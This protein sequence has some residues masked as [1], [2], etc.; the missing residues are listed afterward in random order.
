M[1]S[2]ST[3]DFAIVGSGFGGS[4]AALRLAEKGYRV[5]VL[6]Q[7]HRVDRARM[8]AA[9]SSLRWFMWAPGLRAFGYFAQ[10]VFQHVGILGGVG[11]GGGSLVYG[12]VL[13]QP[14]TA[15][16]DDPA[17][18]RLGVNWQRELEPHYRT[19]E[20]MLGRAITPDLGTMDEYLR[21][22]AIALGKADTFGPTP[23]GIYFGQQGL[24]APDPYFGGAGPSK[25]GCL[26][27]GRCLTGCPHGSKNSLDQNYLYLA[28]RK[29]V[30]VL[31]LHQVTRLTRTSEG[32]RLECRDVTNGIEHSPINARR[33]VLAAGVVGTLALLF[34]SRDEHGTLPDVSRHLGDGVRTNS[35]SIVGIY[36][37]NPPP[38][39]ADG[40]AISSH[41]HAS[42]HTH[43]TQNR[44]APRYAFM[45]F[46]ATPMIDD[47]Q[48]WRR[49]IRTLLAL[50]LPPWRVLRAMTRHD[51]HRR[52]TVLTVMQKVDNELR[53]RWGRSL[54][55]PF[56]RRL[57]SAVAVGA[58]PPTFLPEANAAARALA[59]QADGT[60][61]SFAPESVGNLSVTA[62]I[63]GGCKMGRTAEDG[64]IDTR[65]EVFGCPGLYVV[66]GSAVSANVGVNPSLTITALAE[67]A[68]EMIPAKG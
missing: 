14:K 4:V 34:R 66:D 61:F 60:P 39:L 30:A 2:E 41:F 45:R 52:V 11:V 6:E 38:D 56:R 18:S 5:V 57:L 23:N 64:V 26:R 43:L 35:E 55:W 51:W 68:M 15:F 28:E 3:Y 46:Y 50:L 13:L 63:L 33:V 8:E 59:R 21:R 17:W 67:R 20:R 36:H 9:E 40:T 22:T 24:E 37:D 12:A 7:G 1:H 16:F 42:E 19:A 25:I 65:H 32:Y 54:L 58:R 47:H 29:G 44:F 10:H 53:F 27:C 49:A 62:H 31:P 48:P